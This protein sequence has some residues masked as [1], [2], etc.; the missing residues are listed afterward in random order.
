[1]TGGGIGLGLPNGSRGMT[2]RE[3]AALQSFPLTHVFHGQEIRKQVGNAVPPA[4]AKVL[5]GSVRRQLERRDGWGRDEVVVLS[6][7]E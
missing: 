4:F 1:M 2:N 6:D 3:L 5:L 7:D